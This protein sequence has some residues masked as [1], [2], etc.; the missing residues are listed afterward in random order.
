MGTQI[1]IINK[2]LSGEKD[3]LKMKNQNVLLVFFLF[4]ISA[5]SPEDLISEFGGSVITLKQNLVKY[6][7]QRKTTLHKTQSLLQFMA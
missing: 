3:I 4:F 5:C 7:I 6:S 1:I 2:M